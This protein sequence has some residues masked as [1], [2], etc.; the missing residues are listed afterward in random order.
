MKQVSRDL[1]IIHYNDA[2]ATLEHADALTPANEV[3]AEGKFY[4]GA[5]GTMGFA[6]VDGDIRYLFSTYKGKGAYLIKQAKLKGGYK[7]D[8]FDG[9][10]TFFYG[11]HGFQEVKRESN[12]VAGGP[13][14]VWM[15]LV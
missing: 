2:L 8:C 6:I 12:W 7:L 5:G 15:A 9:F 1:F 14:V 3:S 13:D 11:L 10:L 4:V